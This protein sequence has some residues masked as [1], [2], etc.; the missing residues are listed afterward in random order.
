[1]RKHLI[2]F[3]GLMLLITASCKKDN[4]EPPTST[5]TGSVTYQKQPV[6]V[7]STGIQFEIW[8][9]GYQL[10]T[11]IPLNIKQDGTFS[12]LLYDGD[13]KIVR[14]RGAGPWT[15]NSDTINVKV[16]GA[17]TVDIPIEPFFTISNASF[18]K[19]GNTIKGTFTIEKNTTT[20]TLEV[21]RLYVGPNLIL[22]QN[23]NAA[24]AQVLPAAITIGTPLTV[25]VDI[26]AALVNDGYV[27]ARAG[28]KTTGTAELLY[29]MSQKVML[30]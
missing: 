4:L 30:K 14:A 2:N 8:Q 1:M 9:S 10:F 27:F 24:S 15:D 25:S 12:A 22:D 3:F 17:A 21:A 23:N 19:V 29:T 7:R 28:V 6:G 5:L 18:Q 20:K 16:N 13:Y 11:K 26:P